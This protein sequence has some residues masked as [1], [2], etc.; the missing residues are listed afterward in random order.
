MKSDIHPKWNNKTTVTCSCGNTFTTGSILDSIHVDICSA[1]HPFYTGEM[2]FVDVQGRV[3]KFQA[4]MQQGKAYQQAKKKK[5]ATKTARETT[6]PQSLKDMLTDIKK[7]HTD[8]EK[9]AA[10]ST[11]DQEN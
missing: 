6:Q 1:C 2:K 7:A 10:S 11:K 3:E 5:Q 4:K 8:T 9:E